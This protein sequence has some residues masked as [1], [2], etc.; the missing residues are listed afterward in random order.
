M[1]GHST[2]SSSSASPKTASSPARPSCKD[3]EFGSLLGEGAF[4]R[5]VQVRDIKDGQEYALKILD[6]RLNQHQGR[7]NAVMAERALLSS[8]NHPGIIGLRCAFQ[9]ST[10]LY[11]LLELAG[12]GELAAELLR[13]GGACPLEFAQFYMAEMVDVLAYLRTRRVAHR[14]LKPENML[15]TTEGHLKICDF[16]AALVVPDGG[17]GDAAG[18]G[19]GQAQSTFVG[20]AFYLPPESVAGTARAREAYALDLWALGCIL[21]QMLVGST[22]F[23]APTEFL[24]FE[25]IAAGDYSYPSNFSPQLS[26]ARCLIDDLLVK[27][28]MDRPGMKKEGMTELKRN[29]FFGGSV[30]AYD[31]IVRREP[32]ENARLRRSRVDSDAFDFSS[33]EMTPDQPGQGFSTSGSMLMKVVMSEAANELHAQQN[34]DTNDR[35]V[36]TPR[37]NSAGVPM[38]QK[39]NS[40]RVP[41]SQ[42]SSSTYS[43]PEETDWRRAVTL[44]FASWQLWLSELVRL[45][46][47]APGEGVAICGSI[48]QRRI[49]C[50]RPNVLVLTD[51]PRLILLDSRGL[52][53]IRT[54][55]LSS[56]ALQVQSSVAFTLKAANTRQYRCCDVTM[57]AEAWSSKIVSAVEALTPSSRSQPLSGPRSRFL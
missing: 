13:F 14:D 4:A 38:V 12:G 34:Q 3:F 19:A 49:T 9:D 54:L 15:L 31:A 44:P 22:P 36:P 27:R 30:S 18:G 20:T 11:F 51:A 2:S 40:L 16:D 55:D 45:G 52:K 23:Y 25:R 29:A 37:T 5:V 1:H 24:V 33:P 56:C 21:Y 39:Q 42:S 53:P 46:T 28:P 17:E 43:R 47:L 57:G 32:P 8:F 35:R 6:K 26:S 41:P 48:V 50:L 10:S 7:T